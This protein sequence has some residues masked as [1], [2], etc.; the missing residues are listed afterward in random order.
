MGG[1]K[2][3]NVIVLMVGLFGLLLYLFQRLGHIEDVL[4]RNTEATIRT[5]TKVTEQNHRIGKLEAWRWQI[6]GGIAL[7]LFAAPFV[8]WALGFIPQ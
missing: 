8:F 3:S 6:I 7:L 5:E 2:A 1:E 4:V